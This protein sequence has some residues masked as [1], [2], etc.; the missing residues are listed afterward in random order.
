MADLIPFFIIL[1]AGVVFSEVFNHF[2]LPWVVALIVGGIVTGPHG[3]GWIEISP[4]IEF[5]GEIGL[6]FLMFMAGLEVKL[7]SFKKVEREVSWIAALNGLIPFGAG[8]LI[9]RFFGY[10]WTS[11]LLIGAIFISS[12]IAVV[13]PSLISGNLFHTKVGKS[14]IGATIIEDIASLILLSIMLQQTGSLSDLPLPIFYLLLLVALILLRWA[15]KKIEK[16]FIDHAER[17]DKFQQEFRLVFTIL[18]G[19]VIVFEVLGL[20]GIIAGFFAGLILSETITSDLLIQKL[21]TISYGLFIPIFFIVVGANTNLGILASAS[22]ALLF[23]G[24]LILGTLI[25]KFGSGWLGGRISGLRQGESILVGAASTPQLSTALAV[26][27]AG[28]ALDLLDERLLVAVISLSIITTLLAPI[29]I[30]GIAARIQMPK[31]I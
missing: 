24:V 26:A 9:G 28:F 27:S 31:K 21:R 1:L 19:T 16:I 13:I 29:L 7:S 20:H 18:I 2:H 23:T 8:L 4:T 25:T 5:L 3:L 6:I 30:R 11:S 12:S 15:M 10:D 17:E 14:I 22:N